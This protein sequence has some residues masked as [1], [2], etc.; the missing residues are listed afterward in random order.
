[1]FLI[2]SSVVAFILQVLTNP[3]RP[4]AAH[5]HDIWWTQG[6]F[7]LV[8]VFLLP[9][10]VVDTVKLS[11]RFAGPILSLRRVMREIV[12]GKPPRKLKFRR[13]DFWHDL[14][15]DYNAMLLRL[16][17]LGEEQDEA[18]DEQL[19]GSTQSTKRK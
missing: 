13:H 6:P 11:N 15:D 18:N 5:A 4:L 19:V 17:L 3:F 12:Q 16:E 14:A 8:M 9:V 7:L 10:F 2:V 1:V